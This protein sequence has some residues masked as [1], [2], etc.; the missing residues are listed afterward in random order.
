[1]VNRAVEE[2]LD[3]RGVEVD[4]HESVGAGCLE[5]VRHEPGGNRFTSAVLLI[6]SGVAVEGR[7]DGDALR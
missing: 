7:D 2:A 6:L 5:Q 1:M 3:L 4:R